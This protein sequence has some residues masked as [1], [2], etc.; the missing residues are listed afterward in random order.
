MVPGSSS[1]A[2]VATLPTPCCLYNI[3]YLFCLFTSSIENRAESSIEIVW[4]FI[5]IATEYDTSGAELVNLKH[6]RGAC[7]RFLTSNPSNASLLLL[8]AFCTLILEEERIKDSILIDEASGEI[9]R[10]LELL[11]EDD[12]MTMTALIDTMEDYFELL[13]STASSEGLKSLL[14]DIREY[15]LAHTNRSW[16]QTFNE[17]FM[18]NY[19]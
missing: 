1:K 18:V 9:A 8:K 11:R 17:K 7:I 16:L 13:H 19:E 3:A 6:L 4:E 2:T 5:N 10:G 15:Q 14:N 12:Q